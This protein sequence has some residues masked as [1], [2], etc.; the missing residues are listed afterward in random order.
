MFEN[1]W[2]DH[3]IHCKVLCSF[4]KVRVYVT[5]KQTGSTTR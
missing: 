5:V 3:V 1:V 4:L 2:L